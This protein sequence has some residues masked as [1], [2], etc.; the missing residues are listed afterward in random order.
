MKEN[1]FSIYIQTGDLYYNGSNT[2][3]S[4]YNFLLAQR[5]S[6]KKIT[7]EKLH[8]AGTFEEYLS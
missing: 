5:D 6:S 2:G 1:H 3:E 7:K 8:Y 4:I